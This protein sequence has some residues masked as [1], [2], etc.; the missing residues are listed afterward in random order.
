MEPGPSILSSSVSG[1]SSIRTGLISSE[2]ARALKERLQVTSGDDT[3]TVLPEGSMEKTVLS[4]FTGRGV[5]GVLHDLGQI[6][7]IDYGAGRVR[8]LLRLLLRFVLAQVAREVAERGSRRLA[9]KRPTAAAA[10]R[11]AREQRDGRNQRK[12]GNL[13]RMISVG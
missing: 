2:L 4:C 1:K 10:Q 8:R 5:L 11:A 13:D 6:V 7:I 12:L 9:P 3:L